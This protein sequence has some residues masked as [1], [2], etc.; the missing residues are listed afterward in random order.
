MYD[1]L[2]MTC[3][4][5]RHLLTVETGTIDA[6]KSLPFELNRSVYIGKKSFLVDLSAFDRIESWSYKAEVVASNLGEKYLWCNQL[7]LH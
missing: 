1:T 5:K 2:K 4:K 6:S 7:N 3:V